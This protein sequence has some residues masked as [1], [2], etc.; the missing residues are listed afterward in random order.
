MDAV[1]KDI[2]VRRYR[3]R[4]QWEQEGRVGD[5]ALLDMPYPDFVQEKLLIA[6]QD[7]SIELRG[8]REAL[9]EKEQS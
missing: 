8:I 3:N 4:M 9:T 6:L 5:D 1:E 2:F 7:V